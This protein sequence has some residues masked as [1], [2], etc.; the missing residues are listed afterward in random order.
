MK[1][2]F[3]IIFIILFA[4]SFLVI[5]GGAFCD[6]RYEEYLRNRKK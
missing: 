1:G 2:M 4:V 6:P 3:E 5:F